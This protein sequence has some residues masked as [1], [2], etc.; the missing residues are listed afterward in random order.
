MNVILGYCKKDVRFWK[1]G[2]I[3]KDARKKYYTFTATRKPYTSQERTTDQ[4]LLLPSTITFSN[5]ENTV[6][7][8]ASTIYKAHFVMICCVEVMIFDMVGS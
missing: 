2:V 6:G 5:F 1:K 8:K 3:K 7:S 4:C